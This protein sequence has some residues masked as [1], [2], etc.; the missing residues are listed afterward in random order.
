V[1]HLILRGDRKAQEGQKGKEKEGK[2]QEF[3]LVDPV[4]VGSSN[5]VKLHSLV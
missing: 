2:A 5:H 3:L 1:H 4:L